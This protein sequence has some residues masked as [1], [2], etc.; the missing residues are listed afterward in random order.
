MS[1]RAF[2]PVLDITVSAELQ[3]WLFYKQPQQVLQIE[4]GER[5]QGSRL[6]LGHMF[7]SPP[8]GSAWGGC[9]ELAR[10]GRG[11]LKNKPCPFLA[12]CTSLK[13]VLMQ[14]DMEI[15]FAFS[16]FQCC[17]CISKLSVTVPSHQAGTR[18]AAWDRCWPERPLTH[19]AFQIASDRCQ[20]G[21]GSPARSLVSQLYT[22]TFKASDIVLV[23]QQAQHTQQRTAEQGKVEGTEKYLVLSG[24]HHFHLHYSSSDLVIFSNCNMNNVSLTD[25]WGCMV[26]IGIFLA[27]YVEYDCLW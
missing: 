13:T 2:I 9:T 15:M 10:V 16:F 17:W 20:G 19:P 7:F 8:A 6:L 5:G 27:G 3:P 22:L 1:Q 25:L 4:T 26:L 11:D 18:P 24:S 14:P 21:H 12:G 23:T